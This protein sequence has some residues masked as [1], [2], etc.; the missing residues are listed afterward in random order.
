MDDKQKADTDRLIARCASLIEERDTMVERRKE[1]LRSHYKERTERMELTESLL[2]SVALITELLGACPSD[3]FGDWEHPKTCDL[4][5][6]SN[7]GPNEQIK[8]CWRLYFVEKG[9]I[10]FEKKM[11]G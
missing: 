8:R 4:V 10:T 5:C 2:L 3:R 11:K 9:K 6:Q 7:C 1:A